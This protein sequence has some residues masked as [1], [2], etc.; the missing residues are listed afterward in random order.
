MIAGIGSEG[1][2]D[3]MK[4]TPGNYRE[5]LQK[6]KKKRGLSSS[7]IARMSGITPA[8]VNGLL[9]GRQF[10]TLFTMDSIAQAFGKK[11]EIR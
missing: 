10:P 3:G 2:D 9:T 1:R 4:I 8:S 6:E 5:W 11:I 7:E